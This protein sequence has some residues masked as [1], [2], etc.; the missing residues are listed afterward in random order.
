MTSGH[1]YQVLL[2]HPV[3]VP[4]PGKGEDHVG[5][6]AFLAIVPILA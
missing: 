1:V 6:G 4:W 5:K 3:G 2:N